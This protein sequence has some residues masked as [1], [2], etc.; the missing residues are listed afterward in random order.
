MIR[1]YYRSRFVQ[2]FIASFLAL[3]PALA[4]APR[5]PLQTMAD[6][7]RLRPIYGVRM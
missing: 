7:T 1:Q 4:Q 2:V 3:G 5:N 6:N